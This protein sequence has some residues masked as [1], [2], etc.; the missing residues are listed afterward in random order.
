[1]NES[2][3]AAIR[4]AIESETGKAPGA[5][6]VSHAGG[7]S[8][9]Q[10]YAIQG[11]NR[12]FVK[13]NAASRRELFEAESDSLRALAETGVIRVPR[14]IASGV[15]GDASFLLLEHLDLRPGSN[16]EYARLGEQL[17][18]LHRE[19]SRDGRFGWPRDNFIGA[20]PQ[21]NAPQSDWVEFW[22]TARLEPQLRIAADQGAK[23]AGA[24]RLL[25]ELGKFFVSHRP[26]PSL[27]HG[28]LWSGNASF[29][30][31]GT[32]VIFDP[33]VYFGDRE[34][35]LAFTEF[36]GGFPRAFY[37]AYDGTFPRVEDWRDRCELYNLY[38]ALNHFNL[39]GGHYRLQAQ[40]M[41]QR[42]VKK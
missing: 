7:G 12:F 14:V 34:T 10:S 17:A 13:V 39:F 9:H 27:C 26:S 24:A 21:K 23:F 22:R 2:L 15:A 5:F 35:D 3:R 40:E 36:F 25:E 20:T 41:M 33:A 30:E 18:A 42:L 1:M 29:L 16:T 28:D 31:D 37:E 6:T 32:P 8:I 11:S 4:S 38:H 19:V